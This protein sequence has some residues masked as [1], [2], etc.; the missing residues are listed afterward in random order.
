LASLPLYYFSFFKAPACIIKGLERIQ[1]NFLWGGGLEEKKVHWVSW[2][3]I[4][5]PK[6]KRG[7]GVKKLNLFN[8]GC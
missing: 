7:F 8:M 2:N 5:L 1:R 6:K 3:Q 4:C